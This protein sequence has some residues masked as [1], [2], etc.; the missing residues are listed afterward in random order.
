MFEDFKSSYN[1]ENFFGTSKWY[2]KNV[3][4]AIC[5]KN[6]DESLQTRCL[7]LNCF[8]ILSF[9][10]KCFRYSRY[11]WTCQ[12]QVHVIVIVKQ[13]VMCW[14]ILLTPVWRNIFSV[15]KEPENWHRMNLST[16]RISYRKKSCTLKY[17]FSVSL[18]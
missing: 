16:S 4:P 12:R 9:S 14:V 18:Y 15:K 10:F 17:G 1:K 6:H 8:Q 2:G 13:R 5:F 11:F 7:I 3:N